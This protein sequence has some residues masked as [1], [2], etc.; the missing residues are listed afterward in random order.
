MN[1]KGLNKKGDMNWVIIGLILGL[2]VLVVV[3]SIV[4]KG[5][6]LSNDATSCESIAGGRCISLDTTCAGQR[7]FA[8]NCK[9]VD[10]VTCCVTI[11]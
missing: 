3:I 2:I 10:K 5:G 1:V 9:L 6:S 4:A 7:T 11:P 8:S